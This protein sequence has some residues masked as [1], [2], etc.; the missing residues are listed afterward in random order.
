VTST[1]RT[2]RLKQ[3]LGTA[4]SR[5][6]AKRIFEEFMLTEPSDGEIELG[7]IY[8]GWTLHELEGA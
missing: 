8:L 1:P 7:S 3:E 4:K 5:N 2:A 6:A